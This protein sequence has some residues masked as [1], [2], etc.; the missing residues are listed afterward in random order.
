MDNGTLLCVRE[1]RFSIVLVVVAEVNWNPRRPTRTSQ[2]EATNRSQTRVC[3]Q[4]AAEVTL[5]SR[6]ALST[7]NG[8][9]YTDGEKYFLGGRTP[10]PV[11]GPW[12][13]ARE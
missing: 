10:H 9:G 2:N 5:E 7:N 4:K 6:R 1:Y 3:Q 11:I 13:N 12:D 8:G